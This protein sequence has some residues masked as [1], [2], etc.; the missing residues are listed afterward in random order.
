MMV[1][2]R[3]D[4][5]YSD[6]IVKRVA[7]AYRKVRNTCRYLLSNLY[8]FDPAQDSVA[9]SALDALDVYA[10]ARHRQFVARVLQAYDEYEFHVVFHQLVQYCAVDLSAFFLDVLKDRLYCDAAAAPRRR[11]AQTVL[12]RMALDLPRLMAPGLPFTADEVYAYLPGKKLDSVLMDVFPK[13]KK[14]DPGVLSSWQTLLEVRSAVTK[15]LEEARAAKQ[16]AS[17]MESSVTVMAP[18]AAL[19]ALRGHEAKGKTFPGNL[20]NLFIVSHV[21]LQA[22]EALSVDVARAKGSKCERCWTYSEQVGRLA[23]HPGVC[24]R[25]AAV[26]EGD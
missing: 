3:E 23:V 16:I 13:A 26:L 5:R 1:D 19:E 9:E 10:L 22:S 8:D 14:A 6:E 15:K 4:Q 11:S 25:C 17:S 18:Q 20:A 21:V 24:E 7:E 12:Y 2:Y